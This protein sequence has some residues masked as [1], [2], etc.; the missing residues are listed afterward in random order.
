[1][2]T[3]TEWVLSSQLANPGKGLVFEE[4]LRR[5]RQMDYLLYP[6]EDGSASEGHDF[7]HSFILRTKIIKQVREIFIQGFRKKGDQ[8]VHS[9]SVW[10]WHL[11][12]RH[13]KGLLASAPK[14]RGV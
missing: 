7:Q 8:H 4:V 13:V 9:G 12:G 14:E 6:S 5:I 2:K 11:G 1:M 10:P 3:N